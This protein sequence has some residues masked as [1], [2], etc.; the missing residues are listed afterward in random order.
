MKEIRGKRRRKE[1]NESERRGKEGEDRN[2]VLGG[3][4]KRHDK[5]F[6]TLF[7]LSKK[8]FELSL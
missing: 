1:E 4:R 5:L 8:L 7:E 6:L 3:N 2:E